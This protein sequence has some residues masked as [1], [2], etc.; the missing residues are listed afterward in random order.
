MMA[1]NASSWMRCG[2]S[3]EGTMALIITIRI[4]EFDHFVTASRITEHRSF[5]RT[6]RIPKIGYVPILICI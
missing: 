4:S 5:D 6:L 2:W 3:A 1:G